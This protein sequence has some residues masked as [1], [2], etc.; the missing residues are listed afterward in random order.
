MSKGLIEV[1]VT[2]A[3]KVQQTILELARRLPVKVMQALEVEAN[4]TIEESQVL[5]P[6]MTG[7]LKSSRFIGEPNMV[8][9]DIGIIFGYGGAAAKYALAVHENPRSG[10]TGGW[11]P[12][13]PQEIAFRYIKGRVVPIGAQ[14]KNWA[15]SGQWKYL[16]QP[17]LARTQGF[18]ERI[19]GY[20]LGD[21]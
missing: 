8:G 16:E 9:K 1:K 3:D 17:V 18:C 10:K 7:A 2:G 11:G 20:V 13:G 6:V 15:R 5:V 21:I 4:L 12:A 14:R 19:R